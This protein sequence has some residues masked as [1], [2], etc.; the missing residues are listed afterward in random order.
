[1]GDV[2]RHPARV[3]VRIAVRGERERGAAVAPHLEHRLEPEPTR[4]EH[5]E[6][7]IANRDVPGTPAFV[8]SSSRVDP[9]DEL[10]VQ[11][12]PGRE[13]EPPAVH[14][15]ERDPPRP[16]LEQ[17]AR[18]GYGVARHPERTRQ[19]ACAAAGDEA[20]R[21]AAVDAVQD[22]VEAPVPREDVDRLDLV[23]RVTRELGC[24]SPRSVTRTATLPSV[25][26]TRSTSSSVTRDA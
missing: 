18:G 12:D 4:R 11:A 25:V 21:C 17:P 20:D 23:V 24:M 5:P 26:P 14:P 8:R 2:Q 10:R 16:T 13:P 3:G 6:A 22:L 1:M 9:A 7:S 19:H 15:A